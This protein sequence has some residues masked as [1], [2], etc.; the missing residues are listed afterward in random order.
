MRIAGSD[1]GRDDPGEIR[2]QRGEESPGVVA[3]GDDVGEAREL[4]GGD[5]G[6]RLAHAVVGRQLGRVAVTGRRPL[7]VFVTPWCEGGAEVGASGRDDAA[8]AA[9]EMFVIVE[10][11][12]GDIS[13]EA[14]GPTLVQCAPRLRAVLDECHAVLAG[15]GGERR[16]VGR[17]TGEVY[18]HDRARTRREHPADG[19]RVQV[20]GGRIDIGKN[21]YTLLI[22]NADD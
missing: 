16:R 14:D 4:G 12:A 22:K 5:G 21:G 11:I 13:L 20:V 1:V 9:T 10:R 3:A 17:I 8:V 18:D 15:K 7:V 6:L 19:D 2:E